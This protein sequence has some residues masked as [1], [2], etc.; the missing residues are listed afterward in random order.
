MA[1]PRIGIFGALMAV[2]GILAWRWSQRHRGARLPLS[3][4]LHRWEGE[5]GSVVPP[6]QP[7]PATAN[8][9][10]NGDDTSGAANG[11]AN[12][13]GQPARPGEPWPF[14]HG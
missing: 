12:G 3:R 7:A 10:S 8:T 9:T 13:A 14:P 1:R 11:A 6:G 4:D 5:G 2:G